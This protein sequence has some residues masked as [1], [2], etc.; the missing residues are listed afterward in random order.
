MTS[1]EGKRK[2]IIQEGEEWA[3]RKKGRGR[4]PLSVAFK[5]QGQYY[6]G[7]P[8]PLCVVGLIGAFVACA[9]V[10]Y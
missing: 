4:V 3:G 2:E 7:A 8:L 1:I 6:E 5:E 9:E 10:D